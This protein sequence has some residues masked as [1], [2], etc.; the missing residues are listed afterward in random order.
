MRDWREQHGTVITSFME[1]LNEKTSNFILKGGTALYLCYQ[2]DRFSEDIDL[3]GREKGLT[4]FVDDF[5]QENGYA[6]RVAKDTGT[7]ERCLVDYGSVGKPLKIEASFRRR[8]ILREE[9]G[10]VNGVIV[11][12][13]EPLCVMKINA[14]AGRDKIRDLYDLTFIC[15]HY[16]DKLSPQT[17][18]LLRG[19]VEYKGIAQFDYMITNQPDELIDSEKLAGDFL[20]MYDRLGLLFDESERELILAVKLSDPEDDEDEDEWE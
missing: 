19:A 6:Y 18:A 2:L 20:S 14:Y 17:V 5:C 11:Y 10:V 8:E 4:A 16:F 13:I 9:T 7:V 1:Y 12:N 15:N 3:D